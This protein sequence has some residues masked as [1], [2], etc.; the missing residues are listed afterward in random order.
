MAVDGDVWGFRQS[1]GGAGVTDGVLAG[2][3][4]AICQPGG[5][6]MGEVG[7]DGWQD[8]GPGLIDSTDDSEQVDCGFEAPGQEPGAG[9]E[10]IPDGGRL[11]IERGAWGP[12]PFEDFE[13]QVGKYGAD[14]ESLRC[15]D[16]LVEGKSKVE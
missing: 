4:C 11:E 12:D 13:M 14:K 1:G 5:Y 2:D 3:D 15:R 8:R 10:E 7:D 16:R 6:V 9:E